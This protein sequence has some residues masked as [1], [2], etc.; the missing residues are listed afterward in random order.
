MANIGTFNNE[1][2]AIFQ[3]NSFTIQQNQQNNIQANQMTEAADDTDSWKPISLVMD[4]SH[5]KVDFYRVIMALYK[6]VF[7]KAASGGKATKK[8]FFHSFGTM[9][10]EDYEKCA[11]VLSAGS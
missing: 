10:G 9:L 5:N 6:E 8:D 1:T 7:F 2:G 3:D 11:K 4:S